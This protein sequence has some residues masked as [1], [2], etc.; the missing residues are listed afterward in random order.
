MLHLTRVKY[1]YRLPYPMHL[2]NKAFFVKTC[3]INWHLHV[4]FLRQCKDLSTL[5]TLHENTEGNCFYYHYYYYS[6]KGRTQGAK[7]S[8]PVES[9]FVKWEKPSSPCKSHFKET[10]AHPRIH[11]HTHWNTNRFSLYMHIYNINTFSG[12][13]SASCSRHIHTLQFVVLFPFH[14]AVLKPYFDLSLWETESVCNLNPSA[15]C[16]VPVEVELLL[17]LKCLEACVGCPGPFPLRSGQTVCY[18]QKCDIFTF[19]G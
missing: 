12:T 13:V 6:D 14:S 1:F 9:C 19:I 2:R 4:A 8:R 18:T 17:K 7:L 3:Y 5:A 15:T 10:D 11:T 16:Q